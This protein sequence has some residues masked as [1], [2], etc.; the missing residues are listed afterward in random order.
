MAISFSL[1]IH[2][3]GLFIFLAFVVYLHYKLK[4]G[5]TSKYPF[6]G[7]TGDDVYGV[8]YVSKPVRTS[9]SKPISTT[10]KPGIRYKSEEKCREILENIFKRPFRS[11]RPDFL[12]SPV[13]G[14]NLELDCYNPQLKL[15]LEYDGRQ[16][17]KYTPR[18]HGDS[19]KG[20][21]QFI[22]Q[23]RKDDWKNKKCREEGIC[24][25]RVPHYVPFHKLE[26][27]IRKK[28]VK[29]GKL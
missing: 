2:V 13:T 28:L 9:I 29:E 11:V 3:L 5:E 26:S 19:Q 8:G 21:W 22:Y 18:F 6:L 25:I 23:V 7:L 16:H 1:I 24:L 14:R 12:K 27:Y 20:K 15:A 17:A 4:S 10:Q